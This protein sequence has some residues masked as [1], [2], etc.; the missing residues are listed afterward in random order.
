MISLS[1]KCIILLLSMAAIRSHAQTLKSPDEF[2]GYSLGDRFTRHHEMVD[3][4]QYVDA[5]LAHVQLTQYGK[6]YEDRPLLYAVI[7]SPENF[8][9]LE[10]IRQNNL[11][12]TGLLSGNP[13]ASKIAIVWLS[14]NVHGNEASGMEASMKTLYEL[15]SSTRG[16][17]WLKNTVVIMDPCINPD[18]RDRYANFNNQYINTITNPSPDAAENNEP[19]P[20]GRP[21]HYLFDLNRDWAWL[22]QAE[23]QQRLKVYNQW[24]PHVHVDFHEMG[25]NNPYYFAPAAEPFHPVISNWQREFQTIIGRNNAKHFDENNWLYLTKETFDLYY[26]SY[27]DTYPTY[28]GAIGMTYEQGGSRGVSIMTDVG[29]VLTLEQRLTHHYTTGMS[30][31]EAASTHA[32]R[33]VDEFEKYFKENLNNPVGAYKSYVIKADNNSDKIEKLTQWLDQH[34]ISYGCVGA[35]RPGKGWDYQTQTQAAFSLAAEDI[36]VNTF[37]P[38][39]RF[40]TTVFEPQSKI[41]DSLT[42]DITAWNLFYAYDLKGYATTERINAGKPYKQRT[43]AQVEVASAYAY[44]FKYETLRDTEFLGELLKMGINVRATQKP[45][46]V[47]GNSFKAGTL[48]VTKTNNETVSDFDKTLQTLASSY[49]RTVY[50]TNTGFVEQGNDLG[51][52]SVAYIEAPKIAILTGEGTESL[53][54]GEVWHFFEQQLHYP[55]T[56]IRTTNFKRI[57]LDAYNVLVA[58][59]GYYDIFDDAQLERIGT[60]VNAGG[61]LILIG[62]ALSAFADKKDFTLKKYT[63]DEAKKASEKLDEEFKKKDGMVR[64]EDA[65]RKQISDYISGAIYKINVD[66]SHPLG[67]GLNHHYY[68]L[69]TSTLRFDFMEDA[70]NVGT[71]KGAAKPVQG[72]AGYKANKK[73]DNSLIFGV[74]EKGHGS[75]VYFVDNPLFRSFWEQG[76]FVFGNAV[77]MVR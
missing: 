31:V 34:A 14:Y 13:S 41:P 47:N 67:F 50:T 15:V 6:T 2:L 44:I 39:S 75:I 10:E 35:A 12:R 16:Q 59:E 58:P 24:M 45:F 19:W 48:V 4:F 33:M 25:Y 49:Q 30:T 70:W 61:K 63:T 36:V 65:E 20:R 37:Q 29:D 5:Q 46:K 72:F 1:K 74:Q 54:A 18:G 21:N 27:G 23:S 40:V 76:K 71:L 60:W 66:N 38:K 69:K 64:Y 73:M 22:Q 68:T 32:S 7:T 8:G 55:I 9:M 51:S 43:P 56:Q 28:S 42:Y 77:F 52:S 11:K 3:Y 17:G 53:S 26:P 57:D 62:D